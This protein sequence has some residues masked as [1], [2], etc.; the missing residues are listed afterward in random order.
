MMMMM[1][2]MMMMHLSRNPVLFVVVAKSGDRQTDG[3]LGILKIVPKFNE[4]F[5]RLEND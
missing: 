4:R 5:R 2:M 3:C 1:M